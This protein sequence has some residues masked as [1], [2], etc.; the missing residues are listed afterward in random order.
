[1]IKKFPNLRVL[2]KQGSLGATIFWIENGEEKAAVQR[3]FDFKDFPEL[4]LVDTTGAG[5]CFT[6]GFA[7]SLF[8]G[9]SYAESLHFAN[10]CGFLAI[11]K[12]GA[13]P[14]IPTLAEVK[15]TFKD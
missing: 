14:A 12:F 10:K 15:A 6:G 8:H 1:M 13:G 4:K 2:L 11:T 3:A 7:V 9:R 5:D